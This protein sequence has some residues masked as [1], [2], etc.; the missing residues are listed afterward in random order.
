MILIITNKEDVHP[1]PVIEKLKGY[2]FGK[3]TGCFSLNSRMYF[4]AYSFF[5]SIKY[6]EV[7]VPTNW[8]KRI[9]AFLW[10][11]KLLGLLIPSL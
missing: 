9:I 10:A 3:K 2:P 6:A 4:A 8:L 1:N 7:K 11:T 5:F